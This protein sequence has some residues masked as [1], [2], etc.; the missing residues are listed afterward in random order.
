MRKHLV[1][2]TLDREHERIHTWLLWLQ[3]HALVADAVE[4]GLAAAGQLRHDWIDV[5][6]QLDRSPDGALR[7]SDLA[8]RVL[9]SASGLTR[10]VERMEV[11]GLVE[12][13]GTT[14]DR[15]GTLAVITAEGRKAL[16]AAQPALYAAVTKHFFTHFD[17]RDLAVLR[18]KLEKL[19]RGYGRRADGTCAREQDGALRTT[20]RT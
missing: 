1:R 2:P 5:L 14:D 18:E 3:A 13:R 4:D 16:R 12:R 15:R 20:A 8:G 9:F 11:A 7:M 17:D 19:V 10:L 6:V